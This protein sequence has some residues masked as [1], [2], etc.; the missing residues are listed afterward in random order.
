MLVGISACSNDSEELLSSESMEVSRSSE[1]VTKT[2]DLGTTPGQLQTKLEAE[3]SDVSTLQKLI[4]KGEFNEIDVNYWLA[5]LKNLVEFDLNGAIPKHSTNGD[6]YYAEGANNIS[7]TNYF[8]DNT[9]GPFFFLAMTKLEKVIFPAGITS[10]GAKAFLGCTS[11]ESI[12][13]PTTV[14]S[15]GE[16]AFESC[17][18]TS[19]VIPSSVTSIGGSMFANNPNLKSADLSAIS[20]LQTIPYRMF[21]DCGKLETVSFPTTVKNIEYNAFYNCKS[22]KD[23]TPFV[24]VERLDWNAFAYS[25][26]ES[27]DLTNVDYMDQAFVECRSLTMVILPPTMKTLSSNAFNG[28]SSL[29]NI[30]WP[31][32]LETIGSSAFAGCGFTEMTIPSTVTKIEYGAFS[33]STLRTL[34][35]PETVIEVDGSLIDYCGNLEALIWD[36]ADLEIEDSYGINHDCLLYLPNANYVPGPNWKNIIV[37]GEAESLE[38]CT[39][40]NRTDGNRSFFVPVPFTAKKISFSRNFGNTTYPGVSSGWQTIVLPFTPTR[41]EH[42]SKGVVA[43]FNSEVEGAKPFW[44]RELTADG[45]VDKTS[46]EPNK[47]YIIAMPN[48]SDYIEDYRLNGKITFSAEN[49]D[50]AATP[51]TLTASD[52]PSFSLQPT[53]QMVDRG[54]TAYTLNIDYWIDGYEYGSVFVRNISDTYAFEAYVTTAGRSARSLYDIDTKSKASRTPYQ[55]NKTGIPQIGD[56]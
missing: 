38:L 56:M 15:I 34:T 3:M 21:N 40:G 46:I 2:I 1:L 8:E 30:T 51:E 5:N 31:T 49:V 9:I 19:V 13:I 45:F 42:E 32:A 25:G 44:L 29:S 12:E 7:Y 24:N 52:G 16:Y 33:S 48:H 18:L 28:C 22:L 54:L 43:P 47:A 35:V 20:N 23:Y 36:S 39:D 4:L 55:P 41:I 50:L 6:S 26:L 37:N 17:N 53:Y 10:I 27:V 14:T 11:L